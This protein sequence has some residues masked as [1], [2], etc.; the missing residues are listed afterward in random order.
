MRSPRRTPSARARSEQATT[1]LACSTATGP[2]AGTPSTISAAST[3][4][5][6]HHSSRAR[7]GEPVT[8]AH[9]GRTRT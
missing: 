2:V 3:G 8:A 9:P 7:A 1:R 5:S 4:Q 6:G